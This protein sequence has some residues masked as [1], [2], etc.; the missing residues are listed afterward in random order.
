MQRRACLLLMTMLGCASAP[1]G[2]PMVSEQ[3]ARKVLPLSRFGWLSSDE[4][5]KAL[6]SAIAL[7]GKS[8][9][10]RLLYFEFAEL[11]AS[12]PLVRAE[13]LLV[14][15]GAPGDSI[16]VELSRSE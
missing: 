9:G 6:P 14:T 7:G 12:R 8:R 11:D 5:S 15:D 2:P 4:S 1:P 13:L 10:R 16:E 3:S